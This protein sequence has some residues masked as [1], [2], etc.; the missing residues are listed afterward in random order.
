M[1]SEIKSNFARHTWNDEENDL[2]RK[3]VQIFGTCDLAQVATELPGR[4]PKQCHDRWNI[5]NPSVKKGKWSEEEDHIILKSFEV[6]GKQWT[7]VN[8]IIY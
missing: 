3:L 7:N 8:R 1:E 4:T 2:L 6:L 5:I